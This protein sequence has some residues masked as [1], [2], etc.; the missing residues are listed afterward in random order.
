MRG[1][2]ISYIEIERARETVRDRERHLLQSKFI[3]LSTFVLS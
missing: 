2:H 3:G 1:V